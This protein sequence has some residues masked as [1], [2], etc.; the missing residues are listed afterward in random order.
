MFK[1][2]L[3]C[4]FTIFNEFYE[5]KLNLKRK[6]IS[7]IDKIRLAKG[8]EFEN[9]YLKVLQKKYKKVIDLKREKKTIQR[10]NS[11][12]NDQVYERRI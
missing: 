5:E 7:E 11:K 8:N 6:E 2:Y 10:R 4:K 12:A 1:N 3:N 9:E